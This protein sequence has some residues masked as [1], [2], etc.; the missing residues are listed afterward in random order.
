MLASSLRRFVQEN[1]RIESL[2]VAIDTGERVI[3]W[4]HDHEQSASA[5]SADG[6]QASTGESELKSNCST[7]S[8]SSD[9]GN[10]CGLQ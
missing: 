3:A 4:S 8:V 10:R 6:P 5:K 7:V 2:S 1:F 9:F